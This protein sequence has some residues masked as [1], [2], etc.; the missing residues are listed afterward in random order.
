MKYALLGNADSPLFDMVKMWVETSSFSQPETTLFGPFNPDDIEKAEIELGISVGYRYIL[1]PEHINAFR[2]GVINLHTGYLP[3]NRGAYPNVWP[4][5]DA[6]PAGVTLHYMDEGVDTGPIIRQQ[7]VIVYPWDTASTLYKRLNDAA[8]ELIVDI[9][10]LL[11]RGKLMGVPQNRNLG[12][13]HTKAELETLGADM[14]GFHDVLNRLRARTFPGY[15]IEIDGRKVTV[16]I[17]K[18]D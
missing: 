3:W 4:I 16:N 14:P 1:K 13:T 8:F 15:G 5:V 18:T 12:T 6:S 11:I 7:R 10:P 17:A 9:W 2:C